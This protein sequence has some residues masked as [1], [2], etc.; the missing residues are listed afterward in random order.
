[1]AYMVPREGYDAYVLSRA[2]DEDVRFHL[3]PPSLSPNNCS[4]QYMCGLSSLGEGK[5]Q[6]FK[7]AQVHGRRGG[8]VRPLRDGSSKLRW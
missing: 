3:I 4:D 6:V 7:G 8:F 2:S 5:L 1:M